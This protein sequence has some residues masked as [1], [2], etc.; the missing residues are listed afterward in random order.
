MMIKHGSLPSRQQRDSVSFT[1]YL[2]NIFLLVST[3]V[4]SAVIMKY[5][6]GD[7]IEDANT[8]LTNYYTDLTTILLADVTNNVQDVVP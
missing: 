6:Y 8:C 2:T 5:T 4:Y 1:Y 3:S 7:S